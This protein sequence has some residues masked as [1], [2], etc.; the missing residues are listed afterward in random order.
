[1]TPYLL[2]AF[3]TSA[4][5]AVATIL[6]AV[7]ARRASGL[8]ALVQPLVVLGLLLDGAA[9]L[10]SLVAYSRLPLFLVQ[11]VIAA[12]VV[13]VVLL[14]VPVLKVPLRGR[15]VVAVLAVVAGLVGLAVVTGEQTAAPAPS[16]FVAGTLAALVVLGVLLA[17]GYR[18]GPAWLF[19]TISALGYAGVAIAARGARTTG[20]WTAIVWQPLA[21]PVLGFGVIA[22]VAYVRALEVGTA[23]L[24]ASLVAVIEVLVPAVAGWL[25]FGDGLA[26]SALLPGIA[27]VVVA[28]AGCLALGRGPGNAAA[29]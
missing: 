17:A 10:L 2:A 9:F 11:T 18:R 22:F 1:M 15:D 26:P 25:L 19:G 24:A 14:A 8:R 13:G 21:I 29:A 12:S 3:G 6:Q 27:A 28:L 4:G 7:G 23:A 20:A 5:Y 16:G